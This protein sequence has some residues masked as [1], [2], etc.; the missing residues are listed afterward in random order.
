MSL[1]S[2]GFVSIQSSVLLGGLCSYLH[3]NVLASVI[4]V[5]LLSISKSPEFLPCISFW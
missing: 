4:A 5:V 3:V 2:G 1:F